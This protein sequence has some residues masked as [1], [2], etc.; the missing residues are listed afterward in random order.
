MPMNLSYLKEEKRKEIKYQLKVDTK[1]SK[2]VYVDALKQLLYSY[3][4]Y[5]LIL[6]QQKVSSLTSTLAMTGIVKGFRFPP[7]KR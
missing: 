7:K 1:P 6:L 4:H 3:F 5:I 2:P